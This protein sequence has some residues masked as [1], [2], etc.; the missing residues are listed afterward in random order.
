[1]NGA[2][3]LFKWL[4]SRHRGYPFAVL[5]LAGWAPLLLPDSPLWTAILMA[6]ATA[7]F[8]VMTG[9]RSES[10]EPEPLS[11]HGTPDAEN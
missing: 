8:F 9:P 4:R 2:P 3:Q 7:L 5:L 11:A 1:M 6:L 10:Q